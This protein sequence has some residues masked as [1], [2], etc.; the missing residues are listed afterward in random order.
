MNGLVD[1]TV[2]DSLGVQRHTT[3]FTGGPPNAPAPASC[4]SW[5]QTT[6]TT[7]VGATYTSSAGLLDSSTGAPCS[8]PRP[9]YCLEE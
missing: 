9:L 3:V 4:G 8:D 7:S 6:G 5:T 2:L 1:T